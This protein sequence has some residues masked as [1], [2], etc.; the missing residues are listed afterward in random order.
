MTT[1]ANMVWL[2]NDLDGR[3]S[4]GGGGVMTEY[5]LDYTDY[6]ETRD[7]P[8]RLFQEEVERTVTKTEE[9]GKLANSDRFL[10]FGELSRLHQIYTN[11]GWILMQFPNALPRAAE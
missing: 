1:A 5:D 10:V 4:S 9:W 7:N 8:A 11:V 6:A 2:L 3:Q